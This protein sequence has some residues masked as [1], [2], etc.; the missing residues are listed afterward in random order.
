LS[1]AI[2]PLTIKYTV[3]ARL[4][5]PMRE[6]VGLGGLTLHKH[7]AWA[8]IVTIHHLVSGSTISQPK[9]YLMAQ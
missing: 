8:H 5:S 6:V 2:V 7:I 3:V 4:R 9:G 1:T